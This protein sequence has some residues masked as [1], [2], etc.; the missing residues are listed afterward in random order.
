MV[1]IVIIGAGIVGAAIAYELSSS[2]NAHI[3]LIDEKYPASG[4]T[5]GALG[6]LMGAISHKTQGRAWKLR[7]RSLERYHSLIPEL[8]A[9][10]GEKIPYNSQGIVMLRFDG[11]D[12]SRWQRL[13]QI[14][15]QQGFPLEI[16][17]TSDLSKHC[18]EVNNEQVVGA[19]YSPCDRQVNPT[20]LTQ[21]L[22]QAAIKNGVNCQFGVRVLEI[23]YQD[24]FC[25]KIQTN[26]EFLPIDW[27]IIAAGVGSKYLTKS[28]DICPVLGQAL[29][30][31]ID[32][33][34]QSKEFEPVIT[35]KD[36]HIVPLKN[37]EYWIGATVEFPTETGV[38]IADT[39]LLESVQK[40]AI[41]FCPQLA[42]GKILRTWHQKRPRPVGKSAPV[43]ENL[44]NYV[45][46]FLATGHYRNGVLLAPA[47]A[48]LIREKIGSL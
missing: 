39:Q 31:K 34:D 10:T 19:I 45:N 5:Q 36:V 24:N 4:A 33:S 9:I 8:E 40:T 26:Q 7:Q 37:G 38:S 27:L 35:G 30:L 12:I 44:E 6:V 1:N 29:H 2:K 14:R 20:I 3:T 18:P 41:S 13:A 23:F 42:Q 16:W 43:I 28:L 32:N 21:S 46:V 17:N 25:Y 47:T 11:E 15:Q 22:V 48:Q